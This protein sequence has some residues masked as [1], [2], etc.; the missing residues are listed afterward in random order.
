MNV[1]TVDMR[2]LPLIDCQFM[3]IPVFNSPGTFICAV[4]V[5]VESPPN[6]RL[7]NALFAAICNQALLPNS[8]V[9][10]DEIVTPDGIF[11][12]N[13]SSSRNVPQK[14]SQSLPF[15]IERKVR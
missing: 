2:E 1:P 6:I 12:P 13:P 9:P 3:P 15:S 8:N 5:I 4:F 14:S 10:G 11:M 7:P